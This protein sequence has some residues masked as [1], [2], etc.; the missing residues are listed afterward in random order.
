MFKNTKIRFVDEFII[1]LLQFVLLFFVTS[2]MALESPTHKA[3]NEHIA[4]KLLTFN[5]FS[6]HDYLQKQLGMQGGVETSLA[7]DNV[8]QQIFQWLADGGAS[9]DSFIRFLNHFHNP[10]T[11]EGLF[12][13]TSAKSA[14]DWAMML[15]GTQGVSG[16]YSW[17]DARVYYFWAL[18]ADSRN[19]REYYFAETF[20]GLGQLLHL[21]EDMSSPAHTRDDQHLLTEGYESWAE[22]KVTLSEDSSRLL[23]SGESSLPIFFEPNDSNLL[24]IPNIFDTNQYT[25]ANPNPVVTLNSNIGLSEYTNANFFSD[26]T[27]DAAT[28]PSPRIESTKKVQ[29]DY[30]RPSGTY[31]RDYFYR[32]CSEESCTRTKAFQQLNTGS[33]LLS[34]VDYFDYW[35]ERVLN[36]SGMD[37]PVIPALDENVYSD[38]AQLLMP[39]AIGYSSQLLGYFFRGQLE[40]AEVPVFDDESRKLRTLHVKV[41]NVT[42]T[43]ETMKSDSQSGC[44]MLSWNYAPSDGAGEIWGR[45][46]YCLYLPNDLPYGKDAGGNAIEDEAHEARLVFDN[47]DQ[48]QNAPIWK[49]DYQRVAFTLAYV[50]TLGNEAMIPSGI[51]G[52]VN[53][54]GAVIGRQFTPSFSTLFEEVWVTSPRGDNLVW[55]MSSDESGNPADP[56]FCNNLSCP[57]PASCPDTAGKA[58]DA[59]DIANGGS[60]IMTNVR[61]GKPACDPSSG[62]TSD[63]HCNTS[64]IGYHPLSG[65]AYNPWDGA[66]GKH[67]FPI[68]V[69]KDTFIQIAVDE[70]SISPAPPASDYALAY[71]VL[72][73]YFSHGYVLQ[74]SVGDQFIY[75]S[76]P[77]V[78]YFYLD[79]GSINVDNIYSLFEQYGYPAP[80][81][82][83]KLNRIHLAQ[84][85]FPN[86]TCNVEYTQKMKVDLIRVGE[87]KPGN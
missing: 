24:N 48:I 52:Q 31:E 78:G 33:C 46:P 42:P 50:G 86:L 21:V 14:S 5:G 40:V 29:I 9:E 25:K 85:T 62:G 77:Y 15:T 44:F 60:L 75:N 65:D 28:F 67:V 53:I 11:D 54:S 63:P 38:Y 10:L 22:K 57:D 45:H 13:G 1:L 73:F 20:R 71:Q 83:L 32:E 76:S 58:T 18:A 61:Y 72:E 56:T 37:M 39:R 41:R 84:Q 4:S 3:I 34:A 27:I 26:D 59:V 47:L 87:T 49:R 68:D 66:A 81:T 6:L 55:Y 69:T 35:R 80:P 43:Q 74:F 64:L 51:P 19:M 79:P 70:M 23:I 16:N 12:W 7:K 82:D 36:P 8:N 2:A 17:N 30:T